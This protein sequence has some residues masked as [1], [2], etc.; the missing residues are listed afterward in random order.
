MVKRKTTRKR[1]RTKL[2]E[3]K[4]QLR[5]RMHAPVRATGEWLRL[6]VGGYF[7]YHGVP[8]NFRTLASFRG[9]GQEVA[10]SLGGVMRSG[11]H[12]LL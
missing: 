10:A 7:R 12:E 8:G 1:K 6:V 9:G 2:S 5:M 11:F 4:R 3:I